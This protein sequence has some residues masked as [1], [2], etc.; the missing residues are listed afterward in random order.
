MYR[1]STSMEWFDIIVPARIS[2]DAQP[3]DFVIDKFWDGARFVGRYLIPLEDAIIL[4]G[5]RDFDNVAANEYFAGG[6]LVIGLIPGGKFV[7][8]ISKIVK[9]TAA[10]GKV[11][12]V[13]DKTVHLAY[14]IVNDVVDFGSRSKL[15]QL[16]IKNTG[17]EAHHMIPWALR[18]NPVVQEAAYAGFHMN[19]VINGKV[20]TKYSSLTP[21][22]I[23]AN[24][25]AYTE[26]VE[27]LTQKFRLETP[28]F[29]SEM[30]KDFL[31]VEL[32]PDLD[33]YIEA[34]KVSGLTLNE[35]FK[36]FV[37][38]IYGL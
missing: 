36:Q 12:K 38:P 11:I 18:E 26:V 17:E 21:D 6:M 22:G 4:V 1:P 15:G 37:K 20:L 31:E 29:S 19:D 7:K 24:H 25:P 5:G 14:K 23:H 8:P 28:N 2:T 10:W 27:F 35:Y 9:G 30:A 33:Y 34:A 32:I 3:F 16:L 13:G